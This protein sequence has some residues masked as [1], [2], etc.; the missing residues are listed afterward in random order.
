MTGKI[1]VIPITES[2]TLKVKVALKSRSAKGQ[3]Q[4]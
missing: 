4:A 2:D 1:V 3:G